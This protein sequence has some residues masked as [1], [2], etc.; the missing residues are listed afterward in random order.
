M[1]AL[2]DLTGRAFG[3]LTV[4]SR[5]YAGRGRARWFVECACGVRKSVDGYH[6]KVGRIQSCGCYLHEVTVAQAPALLRRDGNPSHG[7]SKTPVYFVWK[8]M[9][10]RCQNPKARDY[11]HY[12]A[13]G[14][15]V[16]DRWQS[17][18]NFYSDM[19]EPHGLTLERRDNDRG[20]SPDNCIWAT[21]SDQVR[22]RRRIARNQDTRER[23][24]S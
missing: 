16:C 15:A 9:R 3:R 5:D 11:R 7:M 6:M 24:A 22:N 17:F 2:D 14:I 23:M 12:G 10:Q 8:A 13:R 1:P 4:L 21:Q 20:Y 19:G 18:E